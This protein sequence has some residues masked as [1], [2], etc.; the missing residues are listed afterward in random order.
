MASKEN[1]MTANIVKKI[2]KMKIPCLKI[3]RVVPG[4]YGG[5]KGTSDI[6]LCYYGFFGAIE[7]KREDI[8]NP[9]PTP[10]QK[11]YQEEVREALG[12]T[13]VCNSFN[14]VMAALDEFKDIIKKRDPNI[15]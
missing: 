8:K 4:P 14:S 12:Y 7:M 1:P 10:L 3:T 11:K 5:M 9:Q 6:L 2:K 15:T 13:K